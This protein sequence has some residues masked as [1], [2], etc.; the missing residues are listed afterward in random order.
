[1]KKIEIRLSAEDTRLLLSSMEDISEVL[2]TF[3]IS[4]KQNLC[5]PNIVKISIY[6]SNKINKGWVGYY[7]DNR[8]YAKKLTMTETPSQILASLIVNATYEI[9]KVYGIHPESV[10]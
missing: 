4:I 9:G 1:M 7:I 8:T 3:I 5:I 10:H 6:D 2:Q